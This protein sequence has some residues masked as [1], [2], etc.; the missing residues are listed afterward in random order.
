MDGAASSSAKP[1]GV[2]GACPA[3]R[4]LPSN[5]EWTQLTDYLGGY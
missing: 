2:Q 5:D 1:S 3:G 4:H